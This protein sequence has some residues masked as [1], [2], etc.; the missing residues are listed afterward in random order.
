[1]AA[2]P[3]SGAV[4]RSRPV[5][6]FW[7][8][9]GGCGGETLSEDSGIVAGAAMAV[10]AGGAVGARTVAD[11]GGSGSS[12]SAAGSN[13]EIGRGRTVTD[14]STVRAIK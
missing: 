14:A 11:R 4:L 12:G 8:I 7:T 3:A 5:A 10:R 9:G 13:K 1:M 2:R 6:I